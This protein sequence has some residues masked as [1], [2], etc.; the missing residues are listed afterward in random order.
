MRAL[1][2]IVIVVFGAV[3]LGG[4]NAAELSTGHAGGYTHAYADG[5]RATQLIVYDDQPGVYLRAYWSA[6]WQ[7]RHYYPFTGKRPKVGR[8]ER[9]S[10]VRPAPKPAETFYREWSTNALSPPARPYYIVP[11]PTPR[12]NNP[13]Q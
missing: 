2:G 5:V 6:P 1:F 7:N 9:L 11:E 10:A 4:T 12:P 13:P 3:N 8:H